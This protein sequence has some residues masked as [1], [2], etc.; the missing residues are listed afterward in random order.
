MITSSTPIS[1][2]LQQW[3]LSDRKPGHLRELSLGSHCMRSR[4]LLVHM[5]GT[6]ATQLE[7]KIRPFQTDPKLD[8][9]CARMVGKTSLHRFHV[10]LCHMP[11]LEDPSIPSSFLRLTVTG[12]DFTSDSESILGLAGKSCGPCVNDLQPSWRKN[13]LSDTSLCN[14]ITTWSFYGSTR[15]T[16]FTYTCLH[17]WALW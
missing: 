11:P 10:V 14:N 6:L 15:L 7:I 12:I 4:T 17:A 16:D 1:R 8:E 9:I 3:E 13:V 2:N 5:G